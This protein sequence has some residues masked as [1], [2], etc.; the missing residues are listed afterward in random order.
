LAQSSESSFSPFLYRTNFEQ[1]SFS[2]RMSRIQRISL[3]FKKKNPRH[4]PNLFNPG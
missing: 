2:A 1:R 3:M 4:P